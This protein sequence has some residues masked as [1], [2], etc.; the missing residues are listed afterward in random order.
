[1]HADRLSYRLIARNAF[2]QLRRPASLTQSF[3]H[4]FKVF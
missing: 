4:V 1:M 2:D 3:Q